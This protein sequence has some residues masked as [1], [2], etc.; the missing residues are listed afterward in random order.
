MFSL[1]KLFIF[2]LLT[3]MFIMPTSAETLHGE[4]NFTWDKLSQSERDDD[5]ANIKDKQSYFYEGLI[6]VDVCPI[7]KTTIVLSKILKEYIFDFLVILG[8]LLPGIVVYWYMVQRNNFMIIIFGILAA[9]LLTFLSNALSILIKTII[10][11]LTR[12]LKGADV[13]QTIF[14]VILCIGFIFCYYYVTYKMDDMTSGFIS[15]VFSSYPI[16]LL[17]NVI[18]YNNFSSLLILIAICI[19]PFMISTIIYSL[20]FDKHNKTY[21]S[22]NKVIVCEKNKVWKDLFKKEIS[23]YFR[24]TTY[25]LNTCFGGLISIIL[26]ILFSGNAGK[27]KIT[28]IFEIY[29]KMNIFENSNGL[30]LA[31]L[32]I[33]IISLTLSTQTTTASSIS[34]EGKYFWILKV[35]PINPRSIFISKISLNM[36]IF[37]IPSIISSLII[38]VLYKVNLIYYPLLI[39]LPL[40]FSLSTSTLGLL[41]NLKWHRFDWTEETEV[42]KQGMSV[43]ISLVVGILPGVISLFLY[44]MFINMLSPLIILLI[45]LSLIIIYNIILFRI[46]FT[47]GIRTFNQIYN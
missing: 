38:C 19:I 7:D 28:N 29:L 1:K 33:L 32:C 13:I 35:N 20:N 42:I 12:N 31:V 6:R 15:K 25:V 44:I 2:G 4:V 21:Q 14:N 36:L 3:F 26:A 10:N 22:K 47:K 43:L 23:F 34:L 37:G 8:T 27:A 39:I 24:S 46:L 16:T 17:I 45:I 41:F 40:L 11:F 18:C 9:I 5:I 30:S